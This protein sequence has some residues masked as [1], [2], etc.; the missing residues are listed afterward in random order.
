SQEEFF[1]GTGTTIMAVEF[2]DG[3]VIGADSRT[4]AAGAVVNRV[5]DKLT[6]LTSHIYCCRSGAAADTQAI[7]DQVALN[8]K[9]HG[10]PGNGK[11][12]E[13]YMA[14]C[15]FRRHCYTNRQS[16]LAG[17]IVAGWDDTKGG[18]VYNIPL[19]GMMIR[20]PYAI[21]GS[22]SPYLKGYVNTRY[23]PGMNAKQC[24]EL[25][26]T[27]VQQGIRFDSSSGGVV[28]I[29][30]IDKDGM[31]RHLFCNSDSGNPEATKYQSFTS[32]V[33]DQ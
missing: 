14:A 19:G 30:V 9:Y 12:V 15:E 33:S 26:K 18:Q 8:L 29:G 31:K 16:M 13:V 32:F 20:L 6:P 27:A 4:S 17:I 21:G 24:I 1:Y 25:V 7:A 2:D 10:P 22:G 5:A 28:R 3:V 23:K 11:L